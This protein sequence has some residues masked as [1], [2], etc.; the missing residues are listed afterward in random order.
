MA[1]QLS[2]DMPASV[3]QTAYDYGQRTGGETH[4]VV[5]TKPHIVELMLDLAGYT[6]D[7]P[8]HTLRLLEPSCGHGAFLVAAIGRLAAAAKR[9]KA[10][11]DKLKDA[12]R[13]YDIDDAHVD[14]TR[15]AI[16]DALER[17]GFKA[18][19]ATTLAKAWVRRADFLLESFG[20]ERFHVVIGNPPYVRIEQIAEVLQREYRARYATIYDRADL[21]VAFIERSLRLLAPEGVVSFICADRWTSN[22]YGSPLRKLIAEQFATDV[23]IDLHKASPFESEVNAYPAIFVLRSGK[24]GPVRVEHMND[25]TP[26]ECRAIMSNSAGHAYTEWFQGDEPW[27]LS[28]PEHLATLRNLESRFATLEDNGVHVGIGVATGCDDVYIVNGD[29]PIERDR[30]V[31]LLMRNDIKAGA[32]Q[33]RGRHVINTFGSDG[34]P[35]DLKAYPKLKRYF[36]QHGDPI[37]ARHVAQKNPHAWFRTI[38][39]VYPA[40]VAKPKLVIPDI[41]GSNEIIYDEGHYHPHHN[42][43][44]VTSDEWDMQV[45]GALLSSKVAL[46]FIWSYATKM[47]GGY[48]RFQAQ[49]LRRIRLPKYQSID[50]ALR[51]DLRDAFRKR[52]FSEIDRLATGAF[53]LAGIPAFQFVDTRR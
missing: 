44:F 9:A 23:Y 22:K 53:G 38:D 16:S 8:L 3:P 31:P 15:I 45:L 43:Y 10:G 6:A 50:E 51:R 49:Y 19:D 11:A 35:V 46:F 26:E 21:Y 37:R 27:I 32:I 28:S 7:R 29:A 14:T 1:S 2:F 24:Q 18:G 41:A 39:R 40:L 48:L 33:W 20:N 25:A 47:R 34:K 12:I 17:A 4:G 36:D 52:T 13:A 30:L 42:L 5:L